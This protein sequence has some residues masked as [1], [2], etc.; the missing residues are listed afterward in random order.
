M[1]DLLVKDRV[2]I[3][4]I[5]INNISRQ[6]FMDLLI[7]FGQENS[8]PKKVFYANVHCINTALRNQEYRNVLRQAD[9]VSADGVGVVYASRILGCPLKERISY[10][11]LFDEFCKNIIKHHMS[12]YLFGS[13]K[14]IVEH[15]V[16]KL[17]NKK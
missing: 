10:N 1:Q 15:A 4:D 11:E 14:N 5:A 17:Q 9:V 16:K 3:L 12:I 6:E 13:D 8:I 7:H 2:S